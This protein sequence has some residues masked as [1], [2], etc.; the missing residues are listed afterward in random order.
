MEGRWVTWVHGHS[1]YI[2]RARIDEWEKSAEVRQP[3]EGNN[4]TVIISPWSVIRVSCKSRV[5]VLLLSCV[6]VAHG[7]AKEGGRAHG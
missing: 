4:K 5:E 1:E 2:L 6:A 3:L 7:K